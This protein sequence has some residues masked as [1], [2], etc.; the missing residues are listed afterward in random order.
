MTVHLDGGI[1]AARK[2]RE[3]GSQGGRAFAHFGATID[4]MSEVKGALPKQLLQ[5]SLSLAP[6]RQHLHTIPDPELWLPG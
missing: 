6:L 3:A 4:A 2:L 1:G 5:N